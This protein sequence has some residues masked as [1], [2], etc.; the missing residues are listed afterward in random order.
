MRSRLCVR[1]IA[2]IAAIGGGRGERDDTPRSDSSP[3]FPVLWVS[4]DM[5][6]FS[7]VAGLSGHSSCYAR[8]F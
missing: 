1:L 2:S 3:N 4:L 7:V 8:R 6:V 5:G